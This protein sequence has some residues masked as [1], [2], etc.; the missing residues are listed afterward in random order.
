M[1]EKTIVCLAAS[2][3]D[4][5]ICIAGK[6]YHNDCKFGDWIRPVGN[7]ENRSIEDPERINDRGRYTKVLDVVTI[8]LNRELP[9]SHQSEN[10]LIEERRTWVYRNVLTKTDIRGAIDNIP[11]L[12]QNGCSSKGGEN[13]RMPIGQLCNVSSSLALIEPENF[14]I[15]V[16]RNPYKTYK[17]RGIQ[18]RAVFN[19]QGISYNIVITDPLI[20]KEYCDIDRYPL[21]DVLI[22]VSLAENNKD[23][24]AYKLVA[25]VI[26]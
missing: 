11:C 24:Y 8:C 19:F 1:Y 26:K 13:D 21:A 4:G 9:E 16:I 5:G 3:R 17:P 15:D 25:A 14:I 12:W 10:H 2:R 20:E 23:G 6:E 7:R 22:C 18:H